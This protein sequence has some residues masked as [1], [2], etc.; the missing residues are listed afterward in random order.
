MGVAPHAGV[1]VTI[2]FTDPDTPNEHDENPRVSRVDLILG[3]VG[4]PVSDRNET[5]R[6]VAR[7]TAGE[8][9][10]EGDRYRMSITLPAIDGDV[11]VRVRGTNTQ[12]TEPLMD[13][14]GEDPW[15]DLWFYSN[16]IFIEV[17]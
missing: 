14:A 11:Y 13:E 5:T 7:F 9:S 2:R 16:P 17:E 1:D 15:D 6:V 4:G 12:E 10:R 3:E 8:W